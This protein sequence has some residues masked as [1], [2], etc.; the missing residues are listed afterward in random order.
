LTPEDP[1]YPLRNTRYS[2]VPSAEIGFRF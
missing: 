2:I 1:T